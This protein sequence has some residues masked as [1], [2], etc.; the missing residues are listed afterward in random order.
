MQIKTFRRRHMQYVIDLWKE[1]N[2]LWENSRGSKMRE[3][4]L[5]H[6]IIVRKELL[7]LAVTIQFLIFKNSYKPR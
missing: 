7:Q 5:Y 4:K 6:F 3:N 2:C 1:K